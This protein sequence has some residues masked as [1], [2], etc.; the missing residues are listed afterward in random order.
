VSG[1][2]VLPGVQHV[3]LGALPL[4]DMDL[5]IHPKSQ[6]LVGAHGDEIISLIM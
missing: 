5:V 6:E 1:I 2:L 3:L 4:E